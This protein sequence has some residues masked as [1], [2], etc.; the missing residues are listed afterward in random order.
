[1]AV[2][3]FQIGS[4]GALVAY[5]Q[6]ME[7]PLIA[8]AQRRKTQPPPP[9]II[10]ELLSD[11]FQSEDRPW[12][13]R[14]DGEQPPMILSATKPQA[15]TRSSI[16][17]DHAE[18]IIEFQIEPCGPGAAVTWTLL[19]PEGCLDDLEIRQRRRRLNQLINGQ[20]RDTFDQ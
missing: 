12:F 3:S 5:A 1:V 14:R 6:A 15:I 7:G 11:P 19:G 20:L 8:L 10:W 2:V 13:D 16:W 17:S 18:L 9:W 4:S